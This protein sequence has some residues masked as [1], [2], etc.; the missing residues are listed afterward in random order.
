MD[1][2]QCLK[3]EESMKWFIEFQL[4]SVVSGSVVP[5]WFHGIITRKTAEDL[6]MYKP[7][8]C[9]LIRVSESRIGYTLSFRAV[10]RCRHYMIDVLKN[11]QYT[12][13]GED[14]THR[15]LQ[16]LVDFH[17]RVPIL[18]FQE[19]LLSACGQV[20]KD[21][22]DYAELL[23]NKKSTESPSTNLPVPNTETTSYFFDDQSSSDDPPPLP[24]RSSESDAGGVSPTIAS[25]PHSSGNQLYP[26]LAYEMAAMNFTDTTK[27]AQPPKP[28]PLPR[29]KR[30]QRVEPSDTQAPGLPSRESVPQ[31]PVVMAKETDQPPLT[32]LVCAETPLKQCS[33]GIKSPSF[34][35]PGKGKG[36]IK[37]SDGESMKSTF[38]HLM[39]F[40]KK[41]QKTKK[42]A[43]EHTYAEL[44]EDATPRSTSV[45]TEDC[46][47][48]YQEISGDHLASEQD[49][50][51]PS[52]FSR[53]TACGH[54][55]PVTF[56]EEGQSLPG[57]YLHPPPFAPGY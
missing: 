18:P 13:V 24:F 22:T 2:A 30:S 25:S 19:L 52:R 34:D 51:D 37:L 44:H 38:I 10:D 31:R 14:T 33:P 32:K 50:A 23:F 56:P 43:E 1:A 12:I 45:E 41:S 7:P 48:I 42:A 47:N 11:G 49:N 29:K 3:R 46:E 17:R 54:D 35:R 55:G 39:N 53:A 28:V 4:E 15:S 27:P 26:C 36:S 6:L 8:G 20:S 9:F 57:E 16:D 5:E 21:S 40:K